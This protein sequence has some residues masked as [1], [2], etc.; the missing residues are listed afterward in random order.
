VPQHLLLMEPS[1]LIFMKSLF[2]YFKCK[3]NNKYWKLL[4]LYFVCWRFLCLS[5]MVSYI[6]Y[7]KIHIYILDYR[8]IVIPCVKIYF[9]FTPFLKLCMEWTLLSTLKGGSTYSS[10][11]EIC[12]WCIVLF[13]VYEKFIFLNDSNISGW[14]PILKKK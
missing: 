1:C 14:L 3:K 8:F 10:K 7:I 2:S 4:L 12:K 6:L 11:S 9:F 5:K 13:S